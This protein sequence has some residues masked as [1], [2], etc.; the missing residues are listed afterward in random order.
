MSV[1]M[2]EILKQNKNVWDLF[3]KREECN[4]SILDQYDRFS[5]YSS[6]HRNVLEPEVSKFLIENGLDVECN[7]KIE[8][9]EWE[10]K[11][12][13]PSILNRLI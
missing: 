8:D 11:Y 6:K 10:S 5:N 7:F 13:A 3:T 12:I 9:L 2:I 4:P 1:N